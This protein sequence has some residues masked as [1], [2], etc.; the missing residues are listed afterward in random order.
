MKDLAP[1][2]LDEIVRRLVDALDPVGI[3]LFGSHAGGEPDK[4]SD[5]D[6]LIVVEDPEASC[7]EL[8]RQGRRSLWG[9]CVPADLI[10]CTTADVE[11]WSRVACNLLHTVAEKGRLVYGR[12]G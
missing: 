5:V 2:L 4:D 10:V 1:E 12:A 9:M 11:K 7:R 3:Y 8:A 6:L